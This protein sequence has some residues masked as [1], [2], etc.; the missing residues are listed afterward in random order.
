MYSRVVLFQLNEELHHIVFIHVSIGC[1]V[2]ESTF[3][4]SKKSGAKQWKCL[5]AALFSSRQN[6]RMTLPSSKKD[7]PSQY[8]VM[9]E[10]IKD[11]RWSSQKYGSTI[12]MV[13]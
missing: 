3:G 7:P 1:L 9:T 6:W 12:L 5:I 13:Q 2:P 4:L 10:L 11:Y 8:L